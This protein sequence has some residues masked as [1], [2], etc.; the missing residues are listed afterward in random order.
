M[1]PVSTPLQIRL[2][3][4]ASEADD[5]LL[6]RMLPVSPIRSSGESPGAAK[7]A[8]GASTRR[9]KRASWVIGFMEEKGQPG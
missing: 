4:G 8:T 7:A 2:A 9:V 1:L 6:P 5:A 3:V